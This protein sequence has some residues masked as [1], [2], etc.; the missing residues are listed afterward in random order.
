MINNYEGRETLQNARTISTA[1]LIIH[2]KNLSDLDVRCSL[3]IGTKKHDIAKYYKVLSNVLP[4]STT[5]YLTP[6]EIL[7]TIIQKSSF[8]ENSEEKTIIQ[9]YLG[10]TDKQ[11]NAILETQKALNFIAQPIVHQLLKGNTE[12]TTQQMIEM[13]KE[14]YLVG[15]QNGLFDKDTLKRF[16]AKLFAT[17]LQRTIVS[18]DKSYSGAT[19][20]LGLTEEEAAQFCVKSTLQ[21][22]G[23]RNII[24]PQHQTT[25]EL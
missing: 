17:V 25:P 12:L 20:N 6:E 24:P 9:H 8:P 19:V 3:S 18:R 15:I 16:D 2:E 21:E 22:C 5:P 23:A 7:D 13:M 4:Y 11:V 10:G 14:N 1:K